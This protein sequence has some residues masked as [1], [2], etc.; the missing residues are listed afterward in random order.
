MRTFWNNI[1]L[2]KKKSWGW[3]KQAGNSTANCFKPRKRSMNSNISSFNTRPSR[4]LLG[5]NLALTL[6]LNNYNPILRTKSKLL[7]NF[8]LKFTNTSS[9]SKASRH[10]S[11]ILS[12][13]IQKSPSKSISNRDFS[14]VQKLI[15]KTKF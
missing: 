10:T 4:H 6:N 8:S 15:I 11:T 7:P 3:K 2:F 13:K 9:L 1:R 5:L 12:N 14:M